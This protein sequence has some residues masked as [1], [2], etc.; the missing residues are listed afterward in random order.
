MGTCAADSSRADYYRMAIFVRSGHATRAGVLRARDRNHA[1]ERQRGRS[2]R[3]VWR[4]GQPDGFWAARCCIVSFARHHLVRHRVYDDFA[5]PFRKTG[6]VRSNLH[7]GLCA[8][9][10]AETGTCREAGNARNAR[11]SASSTCASSWSG[12]G[13]GAEP[14]SSAARTIAF[15]STGA[16]DAAKEVAHFRALPF[17]HR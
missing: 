17:G 13:P 4:R 1:A 3:R 2:C 5:H 8:R 16:A 9:A 6:A 15:S 11:T 10:D 14:E 12:P 7:H